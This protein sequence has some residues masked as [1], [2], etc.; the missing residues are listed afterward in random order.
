LAAA[1]QQAKK[2]AGA[3]F[4]LQ[5]QMRFSEQCALAVRAEL[6]G[7][8]WFAAE[9][10]PLARTDVSDLTSITPEQARA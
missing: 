4:W 8:L 5:L 1:R 9:L 3:F 6:D 2:R 7:E 10:D